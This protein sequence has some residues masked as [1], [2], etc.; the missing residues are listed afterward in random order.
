MN[1]LF[2]S[3]TNYAEFLCGAAAFVVNLECPPHIGARPSLR[4]FLCGLEIKTPSQS[5]AQNRGPRWNFLRWGYPGCP[6]PRR[7][8]NSCGI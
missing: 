8:K 5:Q 3:D 1:F 7:S 2:S 4:S 6:N